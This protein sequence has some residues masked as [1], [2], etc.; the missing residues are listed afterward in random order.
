[1]TYAPAPTV[2]V[3]VVSGDTG[4]KALVIAL[5]NDIEVKLCNIL[6]A[7][8]QAPLTEK[9]WTILKELHGLK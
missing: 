4:G 1:M 7:Y 5:L 8:V 9:V 2:Y 6:N 3:C